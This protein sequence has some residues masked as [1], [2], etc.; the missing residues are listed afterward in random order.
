MAMLHQHLPHRVFGIHKIPIKPHQ[1]SLTLGGIV[2]LNLLQIALKL[3]ARAL[4]IVNPSNFYRARTHQNIAWPQIVRQ[5]GNDIIIQVVILFAN[6]RHRA[7]FHYSIECK[8]RHLFP[9]SWLPAAGHIVCF[10]HLL[11]A[12]GKRIRRI[13]ILALPQSRSCAHASNPP[14]QTP[15][16]SSGQ[17]YYTIERLFAQCGF[18]GGFNIFRKIIT[19]L[20]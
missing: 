18:W 11:A 4:H 16:F 6:E 17:N 19:F 13:F 5:S 7:N 12:A 2:R 8:V 1:N 3:T 14:A 20:Y 10:A 15:G 9:L